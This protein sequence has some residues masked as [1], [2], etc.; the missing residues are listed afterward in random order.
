[1]E[2]RKEVKKINMEL[3]RENPRHLMSP[4]QTSIAGNGL[5]LIEFLTKE[6]PLEPT[7][8]PDIAKVMGCLSTN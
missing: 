5:H 1:M 6:V 8:N 4:N 3:G 7:N 2:D